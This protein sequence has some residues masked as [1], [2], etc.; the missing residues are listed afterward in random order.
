MVNEAERFAESDKS[1]KEVI[2]AVNHAQ[3]IIHETEKAM[4]DFKDELDKEEGAKVKEKL[5]ELRAFI[6]KDAE[7]LSAE[8]V[9][10]KAGE[11]QQ[12]S[13][14]LFQMVYEKRAA[15]KKTDSSSG[16]KTTEAKE[17]EFKDAKK[18]N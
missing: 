8:S 13:L 14:K 10:E 16:D 3:N 6:A 11:L 1:R 2:E 9:K 4:T 15:E 7:S 5:E 17:A 18:E 12:T